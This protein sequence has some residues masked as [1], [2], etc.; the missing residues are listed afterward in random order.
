M[1]MDKW[2][3]QRK[4][5]AGLVLDSRNPRL[6]A[7]A[8]AGSPRE[9]VQYLFEHDKA[10]DIAESIATR[11][12][13]PN[14]PLLAIV[15]N[16]HLTVVEGNRRLAALKA[17]QDTS[18]LEG[19]DRRSIDRL[20]RR[21]PLGSANSMVPV[22]VAPNRRS[23]DRLLAGRHIGTAVRPWEAEKRAN[24]ILAKLDDGYDEEELQRDLGFSPAEV[25]KA[26]QTKAIVEIA[27]SLDVPD[28]IKDKLDNPRAQIFTTISRVFDSTSGRKYL[29][30]E[31]DPA[32]GFR[33]TT[34]KEEFLK[35][36]KRLI[37]DVA[38][39]EQSSRT[40]NT[41]ANIETYFKKWKTSDLPAKKNG[42]FT[43]EEI[44][45]GKQG[46]TTGQ[47][48]AS[49]SPKKAKRD[50]YK[51][52]PKSFQVKFGNPRLKKIRD[53]LVRLDRRK[54]T[55]AG[56]VLLRV[57]LEL[58]IE[59]YLERTGALAT[60]TAE[61]KSKEK[62]R[63]DKP[64]L[65]HLATAIIATAKRKLPPREATTVER[66]LRYD[67]AAPFSIQELNAFIHSTVQ[68]NPRDIETFWHRTEPLF[69][70]MLEVE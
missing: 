57:F 67:E 51:V 68:P 16:G 60:L 18:L 12:Y 22:T 4:G 31:S 11:G 6:S 54:F 14:E 62:L 15:E 58:A 69:R 27:R 43:P 17:L 35:G 29:R 25:Q 41:S 46:T 63:F 21:F 2:I 3:T 24:F 42:T 55:N 66:A 53:E 20:L 70:L 65:R 47:A 48:A 26:R 38:K 36:F 56:S 19:T 5:V 40:L 32:H 64:E 1:T 9:I 49:T 37:I 34:T 23:T 33:G 39:R 13:F 28:D 61:L 30:I 7:S 8:M 52:I 59:H 50:N 44:L 10:G 45:G